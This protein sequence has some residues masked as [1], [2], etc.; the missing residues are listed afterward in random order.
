M[1]NF[2]THDDTH[3]ADADTDDVIPSPS[4]SCSSG[5]KTLRRKPIITSIERTRRLSILLKHQKHWVS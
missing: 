1:K 4:T 2:N 5:I 3:G